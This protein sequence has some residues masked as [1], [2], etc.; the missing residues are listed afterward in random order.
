[1]VTAINPGQN[2][3]QMLADGLMDAIFSDTR[4]SSF[5]ASL[6]VTRLFPDF[7]K[8]EAQYYRHAGTFPIKHVVGLK[9][10]VYTMRRKRL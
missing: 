5:N 7:K 9:R 1:M 10:S 3:S 2:L 8:V 6:H 4:P